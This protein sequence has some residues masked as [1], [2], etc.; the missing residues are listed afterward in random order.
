MPTD[1]DEYAQVEKSVTA[2]INSGGNLNIVIA[3]SMTCNYRCE[4]CFEAERT[5]THEVMSHETIDQTVKF[6][7]ESYQNCKNKGKINIKWFGGEP[8]LQIKT[9]EYISKQLDVHKIPVY[10]WMFSNGRL[11]TKENVSILEKC[12]IE[13]PIVIAIDGLAKTNAKLKGCTEDSLEIVLSNIA[14]AQDK[15]PIYQKPHNADDRVSSDSQQ[16]G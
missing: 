4:Y 5:H 13:G 6:I 15:L 3:P 11:L 14:Y 7:V 9:I 16:M 1:K 10:G 8:L 2:K 12:H